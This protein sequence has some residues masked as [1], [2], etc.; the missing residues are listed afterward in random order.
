MFLNDVAI[1]G[2]DNGSATLK[3]IKKVASVGRYNNIFSQ[4]AYATRGGVQ[5]INDVLA[6]EISDWV[7]IRKRWL[8]SLDFGLTEPKALETLLALPNSEVRIPYAHEVLKNKLKPFR[9]FH[10]KSMFFYKD[11]LEAG[12]TGIYIGS[13]NMS[14]SGLCYGHEN[15]MASAWS[16]FTEKSRNKITAVS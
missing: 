11:R 1:Q 12:P 15:A 16:S 14:I 6:A 7:N 9:C 13:A 8:I 2:P 4:F 3:L 5:L 10:S